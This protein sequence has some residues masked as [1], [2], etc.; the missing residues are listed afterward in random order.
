MKVGSCKLTEVGLLLFPFEVAGVIN[1]VEASG[2]RRED[3][4]QIWRKESKHNC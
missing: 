1:K 2:C 3:V 4:E